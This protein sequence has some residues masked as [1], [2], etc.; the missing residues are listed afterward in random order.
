MKEK[1]R[2]ARPRRI[3]AAVL[4]PSFLG[5]LACSGPPPPAGSSHPAGA[6]ALFS[7]ER[8]TIAVTDSGLGGLSI[9]AEAAS[10]MKAA[11]A[12]R[13]VDLVFWNALFSNDSGYNSLPSRED[14]VRIF[15]ASLRS[16]AAEVKP[17]LILVGCNTLSVLLGDVPFARTADVPVLGIVDTGVEMMA[18]ALSRNPRAAGLL[19]GTATTI[20][21]GE[22]RRKLLAAGIEEERLVSQPCPDLVGLIESDWRGEEAARLIETYIG[23]AADRLPDAGAPVY[24]GLFCTHF[25]YASAL[26]ERA[27][28]RRGLTLAGLVNPNSRWVDALDP[29]ARRNRF[30]ETEVRARVISMVEIPAAVRDALGEWLRPLSSETEDALKNYDLRPGLFEWKSLLKSD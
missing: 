18:E 10:R 25:G 19:L 11:R 29:P 3:S 1:K 23:E 21:E 4:I 6:A 7:R 30:P 8:V 12:F 27:F 5:A 20:A 26:W 16:L 13:G 17:D 2:G 15:D 9:M 28:A 22:H 24:A 14:K